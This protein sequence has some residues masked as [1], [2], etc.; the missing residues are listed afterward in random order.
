MA[1]NAFAYV[2]ASPQAALLAQAPATLA[3]VPASDVFALTALSF[4]FPGPSSNV[5]L[6]VKLSLKMSS[7]L[8]R[9]SSLNL[10]Q[11]DSLLYE[12]ITSMICLMPVSP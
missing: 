11:K 6:P 7:K 2:W 3:L 1:C 10:T 4:S 9:V 12:I 8:A 5:T